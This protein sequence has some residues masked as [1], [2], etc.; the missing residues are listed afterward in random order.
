MTQAHSWGLCLCFPTGHWGVMPPGTAHRYCCRVSH[1]PAL[2][3]RSLVASTRTMLMNKMKL[4]CGSEAGLHLELRPGRV[5]A[6]A[7]GPMALPRRCSA[8]LLRLQEDPCLPQL[9]Q[10]GDRVL[11]RPVAP[12]LAAP[13]AHAP[14]RPHCQPRSPQ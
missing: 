5:G 3:S 13:V 12:A 8:L 10:D 7:L 6:S 9:G 1:R 14:T 4:S 2:V 11:L